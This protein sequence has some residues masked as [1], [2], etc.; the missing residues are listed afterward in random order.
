MFNL[1]FN[2]STNLSHPPQSLHSTVWKLHCDVVC[3]CSGERHDILDTDQTS[4]SR[5]TLRSLP[6]LSL[7][8]LLRPSAKPTTTC[9]AWFLVIYQ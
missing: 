3:M 6:P 4:C 5:S 9:L 2:Q 1:K 8:F 7:R